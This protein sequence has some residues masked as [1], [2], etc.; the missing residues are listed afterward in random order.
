[1][2]LGRKGAQ[3]MG[4]EPKT[5]VLTSAPK[6]GRFSASPHLLTFMEG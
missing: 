5:A 2:L 6:G 1:M 4:K 3:P